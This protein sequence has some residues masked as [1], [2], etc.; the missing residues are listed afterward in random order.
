MARRKLPGIN[1]HKGKGQWYVALDEQQ[2]LL[3]KPLP[4][5]RGK[6]RP[7]A[8]PPDAVRAEHDALMATWL[9]ARALPPERLGSSPLILEVWES[10]RA[11]C[12]QRYSKGELG[13]I[14]DACR[15][16]AQMY[17][18]EPIADFTASK[19]EELQTAFVA[20]GWAKSHV[21]A[22]I[23]KVRRMFA[24]AVLKD[25][26]P[27]EVWI[28]L[29]VLPG[30]KVSKREKRERRVK[31]VPDS[32][33]EATLP[34]LPE[35]VRVMVQAHRLIGCRAQEIVVMRTCDID[36]NADDDAVS[37]EQ[38][39]W[40]YT[41]G[42]SKTDEQYW[43]GPKAQE[44]LRPLLNPLNPTAWLFP[45]RGRGRGCWST[46]TYRKVIGRACKGGRRRVNRSRAKDAQFEDLP[47]LP[48]WNPLMLRHSAAEEARRQHPKGL[49]AAQAR[50]RHANMKTSQ[51]YAHDLSA[52]GRDV[53]RKLG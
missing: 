30:L 33:I 36:M 37:P 21:N 16:L 26:V 4:G 52:L 50:L 34:R 45:T 47:P 23:S 29:K 25:L 43:I 14:Q 24:W 39:C 5:M 18:N 31:D 7:Q 41:P 42:E 1:W 6:P 19:L 49:E 40:L 53:A 10:Y 12:M 11:H 15:I 51:H 48:H 3:G 20:K 28:G 8:G 38:R 44:L 22:Q 9:R 32:L 13:C 27:K 2:H 17:G 46:A 35:R